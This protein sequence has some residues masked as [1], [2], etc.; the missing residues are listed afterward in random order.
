MK[1]SERQIT[2]K[3]SRALMPHDI[4][5]VDDEKDIRMLTAGILEDEGYQTRQAHDSSS[6]IE[7]MES[8]SP[9]L[10]L[11]DIWLEGSSLDGMELLEL[12]QKNQPRIPVIMI[13]GHGNIQTAVSAINHGASDFIEKPFT[14]DRLIMVVNR[15]IETERLK[16][17]NRE[18]R[19]KAGGTDKLVGSSSAVSQLR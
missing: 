4:L 1:P 15:T 16:R 18:L 19:V 12:F 11:L 13:S 6:A 9:S 3:N 2:N 17:E 5:I 10:V 14:A 8:R 7:S